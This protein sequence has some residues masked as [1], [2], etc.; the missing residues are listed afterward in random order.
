MSAKIL[1]SDPVNEV[2]AETLRTNGFEVDQLKLTKEEL[3]ATI[4]VFYLQRNS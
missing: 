3:L 1:I 4:K 2:C